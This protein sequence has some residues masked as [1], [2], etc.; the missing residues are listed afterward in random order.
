MTKKFNIIK[1][2]E[3]LEGTTGNNHAFHRIDGER[4]DVL[5]NGWFSGAK[6][7]NAMSKA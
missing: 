7:N 4:F 1:A 2:D 5:V 3:F 6:M